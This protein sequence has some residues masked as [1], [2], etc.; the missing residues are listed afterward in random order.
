MVV[1]RSK[2]RG[3]GLT[4]WWWGKTGKGSHFHVGYQKGTNLV[5]WGGHFSSPSV[6]KGGVTMAS[7]SGFFS[8]S[9]R[10]SRQ[11]ALHYRFQISLIVHSFCRCVTL[12]LA[13]QSL[14]S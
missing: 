9:L 13:L 8:L 6:V 12:H 10:E 11:F 2:T 14:P 7:V 5:L 1:S 4:E 3:G